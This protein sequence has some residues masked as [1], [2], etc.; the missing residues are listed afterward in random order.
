MGHKRI[1]I[2]LIQA[3]TQRQELGWYII[4]LFEATQNITDIRQL[5]DIHFFFG[6]QQLLQPR[7]GGGRRLARLRRL[8]RLLRR[9]RLL[10]G[11][12]WW[13]PGRWWGARLR[14]LAR[15]SRLLG[16]RLLTGRQRTGLTRDRLWLLAGGTGLLGCRLL[17]G[18]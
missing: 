9:W 5:L 15:G 8:T 6:S 16:W 10:I 11:W 18:R 2:N 4:A 1:E 14:L 3:L 17:T 7:L 13:L 12:L